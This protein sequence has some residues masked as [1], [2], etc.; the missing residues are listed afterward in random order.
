MSTLRPGVQVHWPG[1]VDA[2]RRCEPREV[3]L[4]LLPPYLVTRLCGARQVAVP[5]SRGSFDAREATHGGVSGFGSSVFFPV[6]PCF[7]SGCPV[8]LCSLLFL[9][10]RRSRPKS[11][12]GPPVG[13]REST[14]QK[15]CEFT[16]QVE[17]SP[18][19]YEGHQVVERVKVAVQKSCG[20]RFRWN[21]ACKRYEGHHHRFRALV[22]PLP[23]RSAR[24]GLTTALADAASVPQAGQGR[25]SG[26]GSWSC[27]HRGW[28]SV[29]PCHAAASEPRV[30]PLGKACWQSPGAMRP[31]RK[32][33]VPQKG[34]TQSQRDTEQTTRHTLRGVTTRHA[35]ARRPLIHSHT[36]TYMHSYIHAF[37]HSYI[38]TFIHSYIH[39]YIHTYLAMLLRLSATVAYAGF[40]EWWKAWRHW[41]S[42]WTIVAVQKPARGT[43][44]PKPTPCFTRR[45]ALFCDPELPVKRRID[46]FYST[47]V[48]AALHFMFQAL[49]IWE[50]GKLRRVLCLRRRPNECCVDNMK[51]TGVIVARQL[52]KHNQPRVQTLAMRRVRIAAWQM[53]SCPSD[54]KGRR[55]WEESATWRC[56]EMWRDEYIKLSKEDYR[57]STQRKRPLPGRPNYWER[58]FTRFL[59][60]AWIPKLKACKKRGLSGYP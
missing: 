57:N 54:A 42:G 41:E 44:S 4:S 10:H 21:T 39:T 23:K 22:S 46:A 51:R 27:A 20:S 58:P 52:K 19:W 50:L 31:S 60:D 25:A 2:S 28:E 30:S 38:H 32:R 37:I 59:G 14:A 55:Y 7:P 3:L 17:Y 53:A 35:T 1:L 16:L 18:K 11:R 45:K 8:W 6:S 40:G 15:S 34:H 29:R 33:S 12:F 43:G 36:H 13:W 49:R 9:G 26:S 56:D 24:Q 47:C 48:P 5:R